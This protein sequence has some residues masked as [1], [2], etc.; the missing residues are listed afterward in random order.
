MK[1]IQVYDC[2]AETIEK[3]CEDNDMTE[4]ELIELLMD[5]LEDLKRDANLV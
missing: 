3:V 2:E 1:R 5:Y 4:W